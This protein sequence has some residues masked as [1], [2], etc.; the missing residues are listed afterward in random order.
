V[1]LVR[2]DIGRLL[3]DSVVS[4]LG[5]RAIVPD[6]IIFPL[7]KFWCLSIPIALSL[8]EQFNK[9]RITPREYLVDITS[10]FIVSLKLI[11][12]HLSLNRTTVFM[13]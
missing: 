9:A 4:L 6:F 3:R 10:N 8:R 12:M 2:F 5:A 13:N 7:A 1:V 11:M